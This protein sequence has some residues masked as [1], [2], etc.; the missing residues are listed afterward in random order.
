MNQ[1]TNRYRRS[2]TCERIASWTIT[3]YQQGWTRDVN[4]RNRDQTETRRL[5]V[6]VTETDKSLQLSDG[7]LCA[8]VTVRNLGVQFFLVKID[9]QDVY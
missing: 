7:Q 2:H 3:G 5:Q 6:D 8:A 4:G 9:E 1:P